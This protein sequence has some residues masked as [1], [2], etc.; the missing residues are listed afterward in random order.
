MQGAVLDTVGNSKLGIVTDPQR[1]ER[2]KPKPQYTNNT[3]WVIIS[4]HSRTSK[5]KDKFGLEEHKRVAECS[6]YGGHTNS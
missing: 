1:L 2:K 6:G 4:V 5:T 3:K